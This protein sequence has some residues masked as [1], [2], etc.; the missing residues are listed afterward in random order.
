MDKLSWNRVDDFFVDTLVEQDEALLAAL[1]A[2]RE[3]NLPAIDV[4]PN[5]GKLLHIY[6]RMMGAS[7]IL[8]IGTLGGYSTIWLARA[9]PEEGKVITLEF[10]PH[11]AE[12][13]AKN[14]RHAGLENRVTLL[15]GPALDSLP[16]L[17]SSAPFDLIF[18]DADKR[19]NPAYLEWALKYSRKGTVIIGDNVV[20][21]GRVADQGIEDE[22]VKGIRQFLEMQGQEKRLTVT[23]VQTVG[24]KGWDG[25]SIAIVN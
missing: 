7:R 20:R 9:L 17:A 16:K 24:S 5:Q 11:H 25:F 4:S 15:V 18:I 2:N 8:E 13:A 14:I 22:H 21:E 12:I 1:A 6:A 23:A 10:E 19:N 3:A